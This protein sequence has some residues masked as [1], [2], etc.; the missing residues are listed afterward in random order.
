M[1]KWRSVGLVRIKSS[2]I[3]SQFSANSKPNCK[4]HVSESMGI[5]ENLVKRTACR[6]LMNLK[7][8]D[9]KNGEMPVPS[10]Q[11]PRISHD[12]RSMRSAPIG[13]CA[14]GS[15]PPWG[16]LDG[17]FRGLRARC[18]GQKHSEDEGTTHDLIENKGS[19]S[20]FGDVPEGKRLK[21]VV[22]HDVEE[23]KCSY[24]Y[25]SR[26]A[27][28]RPPGSSIETALARPEKFPLRHS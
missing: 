11:R 1:A 12:A 28:I 4:M 13:A 6:K 19:A 3:G 21:M 16:G 9:A 15:C 18:K 26:S 20:K 22:G 5:S 10:Q 14:T 23:N 25:V 8:N 7:V 24:L 17:C 27:S 2:V